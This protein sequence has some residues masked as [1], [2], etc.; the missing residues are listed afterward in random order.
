MVITTK[1]Q[2]TII[3]RNGVEQRVKVTEVSD[4]QI[5]YHLW[6]NL[7]GPVYAKS[8]NDIFMIKY[9][10]GHKEVYGQTAQ[11][12]Q[13]QPTVQNNVQQSQGQPSVNY[14]Y[15]NGRMEHDRGDLLL[16]GRTL[17]D[18]EIKN[19]FGVNGFETYSSAVKQRS[20]GKWLVTMG[21]IDLVAGVLLVALD[22]DDYYLYGTLLVSISQIELPLGYA[23]KGIGNGR[24]NWLAS[25]YNS[26][27]QLTQGYSVTLGPS[28][29]CAPS[30]SGF[31]YGMGAGLTLRF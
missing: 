5:K 19:I 22:D 14:G 29:V 6:D 11:S 30:P 24:L 8:V 9:K 12:A 25:S 10:G 27:S 28:L 3:F 18:A 26:G 17:R 20:S 23:F 15:G 1:A 13:Q 7:E 2:D 21:W 31:Q 4:T 16:N